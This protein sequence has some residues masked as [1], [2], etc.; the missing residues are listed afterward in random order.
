MRKR[1]ECRRW[2][3]ERSARDEDRVDWAREAMQEKCGRIRNAKGRRG[4]G[5]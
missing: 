5:E 2:Q 1:R 3:K 4:D